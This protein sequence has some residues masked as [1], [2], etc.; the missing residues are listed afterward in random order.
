MSAHLTDTELSD[1]LDNREG[2]ERRAEVE[3]HLAACAECR[4]SLDVLAVFAADLD[5]ALV[6]EFVDAAER[7]ATEFPA[8]LRAAA[9]QLKAE[10]E[11]ARELLQ[12]IIVTPE[13]LRRVAL[14]E[15]RAM[16]TAGVVRLLC[17]VSRELR[18]REPKQALAL[19]DEALAV[20]QSLS[21]DRYTEAVRTELRAGAWFERS[22]VLRY[23]GDFSEA[24]HS[25]DNAEA[26]YRQVPLADRLLA[27]VKYTRS[28]IYMK[29]E[30]MAEA[31]KLAEE[32]ARVFSLYGDTE[33]VV[34]ARMVVGGCL[35][36]QGK[37]D[38][39]RDLFRRLLPEAESLGDPATVARCLS[40]LANAQME[41]G[42]LG[43]A[44]DNFERAASMYERLGLR[45]EVLRS[46]WG[47]ALLLGMMGD[48]NASV[49]R[50]RTIAQDMLDLE[51][52]TDYAL[53]MLDA[54]GILFAVHE[55]SKLPSICSTLVGVFAAAG[56]P[57]N[58]RMAL[59]YID[60][61]ASVGCLSEPLIVSVKGYLERENY[62]APFVPPADSVIPN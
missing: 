58:A 11:K 62:D 20:A 47:R 21:P 35:L 16:H 14:S 4:A 49:G 27:I 28:V 1:Y 44:L 31:A 33:R 41:V 7:R 12:A 17:S 54:V 5:A 34:H 52:L 10:D 46:R 22:N 55:R 50:L 56:M 57:E 24:L 23:L 43:A 53:V 59:A 26:E 6:W 30:R 51:L 36:Y 37:H 15:Q 13:G 9:E 32:C 42:E 18:E 3:S 45:T 38:L 2:Y 19:A 29:S 61:A 8:Q 60:A 39:A 48:I 40:N 25:L